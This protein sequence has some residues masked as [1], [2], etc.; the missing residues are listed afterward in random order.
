M[1]IT[2][3]SESVLDPGIDWNL[4]HLADGGGDLGPNERERNSVALRDGQQS[5][6]DTGDMS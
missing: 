6:W 4:A 3:G 1:S 5:R 2:P